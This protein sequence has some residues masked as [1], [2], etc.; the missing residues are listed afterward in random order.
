MPVISKLFL[1]KLVTECK[2]Y[3]IFITFNTDKCC[4]TVKHTKVVWLL[5]KITLCAL[6]LVFVV[7]L[8]C[9]CVYI[10]ILY[11]H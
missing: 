8:L 11:N 6:G 5:G 2:Q 4:H 1:S 9:V 3:N 7:W 10:Y